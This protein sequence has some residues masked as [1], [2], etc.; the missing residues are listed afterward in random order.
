MKSGFFVNMNFNFETQFLT[1]GISLKTSFFIPFSS[2]FFPLAKRMR[3]FFI[4]PTQTSTVSRR[5]YSSSAVKQKLTESV[6]SS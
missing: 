6:K 4:Q 5:V 3:R 1:I 2:T